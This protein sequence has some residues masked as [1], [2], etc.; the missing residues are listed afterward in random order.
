[1]PAVDGQSEYP[2]PIVFHTKASPPPGPH[3]VSSTIGSCGGIGPASLSGAK[4]GSVEIAIRVDSK[5]KG[6][7]T[8]GDNAYGIFAGIHAGD[9][10]NL[11]RAETRPTSIRFHDD[12][13][14][15][16]LEPKATASGTLAILQI[17][18]VYGDA[19]IVEWRQIYGTSFVLVGVMTN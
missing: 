15:L 18:F 10:L 16:R 17:I 9:G 12:A 3:N 7:I 2:D 13:R 11:D 4:K 5:G 1:L 8:E 6:L 19:I 14:R